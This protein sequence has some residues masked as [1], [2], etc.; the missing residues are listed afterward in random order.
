L[1]IGKNLTIFLP[2]GKNLMIFLPD[3]EKFNDF[4]PD[5]KKF[6]E[7]FVQ[8]VKRGKNLQKGNLPPMGV[9][10]GA[11]VTSHVCRSLFTHYGLLC[12]SHAYY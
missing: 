8:I 10:L 5:R 12:T 4:L 9:I 3:R 7:K 1:P 6:S 11:L 2:I